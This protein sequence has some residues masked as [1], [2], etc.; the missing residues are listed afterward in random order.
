MLAR[1]WRRPVYNKMVD[2]DNWHAPRLRAAVQARRLH[3]ASPVA[4]PIYIFI[5]SAKAEQW[6]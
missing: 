1:N 3:E 6:N 4:C 5:E 2:Q